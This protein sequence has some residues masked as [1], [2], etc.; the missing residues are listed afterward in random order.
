MKFCRLV[1]ASLFIIA[2]SCLTA[3]AQT[4]KYWDIDTIDQAGAGGATP[5]GTWDTGTTANWNI[6]AD[7]TGV[8]TTWAAGDSAVFSAGS[9]AT[10]SFTVTVSGTQSLAGLTMEDGTVISTS[11]GTLDFGSTANA[12]INIATGTFSEVAGTVFAGSA[13]LVKSG[14]GTLQLRGTNTYSNTAGSGVHPYLTINGGTVDFTTDLNLGA[15]PAANTTTGVLTI[16]GGT[17]KYNNTTALTL[18]VN[19]NVAIGVNGATIEVTNSANTGLSLPGSANGTLALTGRPP[20]SSPK[21][22]QADLL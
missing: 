15:V 18:N 13:G 10:G 20:R 12:P 5:S 9:D 16:N 3:G 14:A 21:Q 22:V 17:L 6:N 1:I 11:G 8:P 7:G 19:R 4:T 2:G